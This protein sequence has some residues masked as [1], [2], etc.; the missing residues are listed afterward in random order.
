MCSTHPNA[1]CAVIPLYLQIAGVF[2]GCSENDNTKNI[3]PP[4]KTPVL[5]ITAKCSQDLNTYLGLLANKVVTSNDL[6][7]VYKVLAAKMTPLSG[8]FF[9]IEASKVN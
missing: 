9:D 7:E 8:M 1:H 5:D 2:G 6:G 3:S 4:P